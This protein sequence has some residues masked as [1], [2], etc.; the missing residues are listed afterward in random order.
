MN[1]NIFERKEQGVVLLTC[2]VFLLVLL[3]MLRFVIVS[4]RTEEQKAGIDLDIV[5]AREAAQSALNFVEFYFRQ[6]G[7][8]YCEQVIK[9]DSVT[10]QN[11]PLAYANILFSLDDASLNNLTSTVPTLPNVSALNNN[12]IYTGTFLDANAQNCNPVWICV[13]WPAQAHAVVSSA[14]NQ[15][16]AVAGGAN[17]PNAN[18]SFI[19]CPANACNN[20]VTV[21]PVFI[22]ERLT[23]KELD[24]DA[25]GLGDSSVY[26]NGSKGVILRVTA[27]GFGAGAANA[28]NLTN[29]MLQNTYILPNS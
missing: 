7:I 18:L 1:K 10:C 4:A 11:N 13:D 6:Q 5:T 17:A 29:V 23:A 2:L 25:S 9:E 8:A 3:L 21:Q 12:G 24:P 15:R 27:V 26:V 28:D 16:S 20:S 19:T 22:I 14:I